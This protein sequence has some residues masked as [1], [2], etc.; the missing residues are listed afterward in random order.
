MATTVEVLA[1][2]F[3]QAG[4]PFIVGHP[5]GE[6]VE[7][8][9]AARQIGSRFLL[10]K[11]EVAGAM[12]AATWGEITGSPGVCLSTRG[13]GAANMV[14]GVA[15][16][17][18]DRA[19]LIAITD[20]YARPTFETGLRQ[21]IDQQ[22][23]Y[24]PLVK[25]TTT[26]DARTVRQQLRRAMRT[27][28]GLPP[29]PVHF[30]LPQSE[31]TREAGHYLAEPPLRP[32]LIC[33]RPERSDLKGVL[34]AIGRAKQ[35]IL[36]AGLGVF[37]AQAAPAFV[38]FAER[39]GAPVLTTSKCKGAIPEDHPLRAGCIIGG[40]IERNLVNQSDLVITIG[41]DAVELQP[42]PWPY[43]IPVL[44]LASTP[45]LDAFV[46]ADPEVVG[47]LKS[48]LAALTELAPEGAGWGEKAAR[49]FR[50]QVVDA[51]N[52]PSTGLSPQRAMEVARAVLPRNTIATC[53]AGASRL[54]VVQKWEAYAPREFLTSNGLGSMGYAVPGALAARIAY[55]DRP[56]VAFTGDG[57]FLMTIAE[58]QTA[59]R[60]NLPIIV[61]VFDD[62]EIGLIRVKQEIKGIPAHGVQ[63]GGVDWEKLAHS[64]GADGVV[65]DTE[66]GLSNALS[67]AVKSKRTTVI[68]V[69]IDASGYVAQFNAL[70]EL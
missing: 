64:F 38:R 29:G 56:V 25:W 66:Q 41:L 18:L 28:T 62:Q 67:A 27:A 70:R 36:L 54:L 42:K 31:T 61:L 2:A 32:H 33:P 55:P 53:D 30:E 19:P 43:T 7:L 57:G 15:H 11:Q 40:I 26:I 10:M 65:V 58:L 60:E 45:S 44:S 12:L 68:G 6:S 24:A 48:L 20:A 14:N 8:M 69:R 47:E 16:A 49:T 34:D 39:L 3:K 5:G 4:T 63:I 13:P 22:A 50:Q 52:T 37:W 23:L 9:E 46:P 51:L 17:L 21:R 59:Q 35:P 1:E